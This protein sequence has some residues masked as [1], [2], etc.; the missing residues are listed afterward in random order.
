MIG[1]PFFGFWLESLFRDFC[2]YRGCAY[3]QI[4]VSQ[5]TL[6]AHHS[7]LS[8]AIVRESR[9]TRGEF[10]RYYFD[11]CLIHGRFLLSH[12]VY[13]QYR[14]IINAT[15]TI[16]I[17]WMTPTHIRSFVFVRFEKGFTTTSCFVFRCLP[18][19]WR[20]TT[21]DRNQR[22]LLRYKVTHTKSHWLFCRASRVEPNSGVNRALQLM[23]WSS[24]L[25]LSSQYN[26]REWMNDDRATELNRNK[27]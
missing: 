23:R 21:P 25:F 8:L 10:E 2:Q 12:Q 22:S 13:I 16:N 9:F 11:L 15:Y 26:N 6:G 5:V 19:I 18:T 3:S 24:A 4:C 17:L 20:L 27:Y 1:S 7:F 14:V